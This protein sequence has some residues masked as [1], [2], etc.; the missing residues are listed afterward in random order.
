M[1]QVRFVDGIFFWQQLGK[2]PNRKKK[3]NWLWLLVIPLILS[4]L[5]VGKLSASYILPNLNFLSLFR[6]G[7]FLVLFQNN[8]ELRSSGGFIGSYAVVEVKNY[9]V[10]NISFNTNIYAL[11]NAF[12]KK[13]YV[14]PPAAMEKMLN[15]Q[16]WALRDAN[17]DASFSDAASDVAFFYEQESGDKIDGVVGI[18]AKLIVDL[19]KIT[20]PVKLDKSDVI[21]NADNFYYETQSQIERIYYRNPENWVINEPKSFLKEMYPTILANA[22]KDKVKLFNLVKN[23]LVTKEITFY[24]KDMAKQSLVEK[25]NLAGTIPTNQQLKDEFLVNNNVDYLYI[26]SNSYSGNKSSLS[27]KQDVGYKLTQTSDYGSRMYLANLK[28]SRV[29][30]GT[31]DWPDGKNLDWLRVFAPAN[32]QFLS[33]TVNQKDISSQFEVSRDL[34][35]IYFGAEITTEPG[36]ANIIEINYLVPYESNYNLLVQKQPGKNDESLTVN[37]DGQF[38]FNGILNQDTK[39]SKK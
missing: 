36:Q 22:L 23:E 32:A 34:D 2:K 12:A 24:F 18:N 14:K 26:N 19:L 21:I 27:I 17:Y 7:K 33:A 39:V 5:F 31:Y 28:I 1:K 11:D 16:T 13:A 35:K 37:V 10:Q 4:F 3:K 25:H 9:E 29:H 6:D 20:G 8:S 38:L 30:A 15:G